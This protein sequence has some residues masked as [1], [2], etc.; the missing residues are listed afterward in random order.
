M[1]N[2]VTST[3]LIT[4]S[5]TEIITILEDGFKSIYGSDINLNSNSP[6]AQ[7]INLFAQ[8]KVDLLECIS[9]VYAS[10]DPDQASGSVL[11]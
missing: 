5:L 11:D 7:M 2:A 8:A 6:D 10:F 4:E 9:Q 1:T 3:G